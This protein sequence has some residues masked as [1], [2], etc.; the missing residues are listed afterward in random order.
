[1]LYAYD[2]GTNSKLAIYKLSTDTSLVV[3]TF[4]SRDDVSG[5]KVDDLFF[6]CDGTDKIGSTSAG[7]FLGYT[8]TFSAG[9]TITGATSGATGVVSSILSGDNKLVLSTSTGTFQAENISGDKGGT[10]TAT[11]AQTYWFELTNSVPAKKMCLYNTYNGSFLMTGNNTNSNSQ[12]YWAQ[13]DTD[14]TKIP[15]QT[16]TVAIPP[17]PAGANTNL[18]RGGGQLNQLVAHK[19]LVVA[20]YNDA[21]AAFRLEVINVGNADLKQIQVNTHQEFNF[22]GFNA[23]S[24]PYG[25]FYTNENGIYHATFP[26][27][28]KIE[29]E[30]SNI[31]GEDL[32]EDID[33]TDS[34]LQ[35]DGKTRIYVF[36]KKDNDYNDFVLVYDLSLKIWTEI[37]GWNIRRACR[38]ATGNK[39]EIYGVS[40]RDGSIYKLLDGFTDDGNVIEGRILFRREDNGDPASLNDINHFWLQ[41]DL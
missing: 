25:V 19:D 24:T 15:F 10:G 20:F 31:L 29:A 32:M 7:G 21:T 14:P 3:K 11:G 8:G 18:F 26:S 9:E 17:D 1:L 22:G 5:V 16:W 39:N 4:T 28:N 27:G 38:I 30:I 13:A 2:D 34:D 6:A 33:F 12:I 41:G 40:S 36:C 37:T 35:W 23:I